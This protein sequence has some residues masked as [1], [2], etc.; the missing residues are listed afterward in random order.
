MLSGL[1]CLEAEVKNMSSYHTFSGKV[2]ANYS[3]SENVWTCFSI[4]LGP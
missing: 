2:T 1:F 3:A 4:W